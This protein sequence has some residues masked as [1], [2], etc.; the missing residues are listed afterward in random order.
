MTRTEDCCTEF[1]SSCRVRAKVRKYQPNL[2]AGDLQGT[3]ETCSD[4]IVLYSSGQCTHAGVMYASYTHIHGT[5][6]SKPGWAQLVPSTE[7]V[8]Q[9]GMDRCRA[10]TELS[11]R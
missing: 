11:L 9:G 8:A 10:V 1:P 2:I 7:H 5:R 3:E 4:S 6:F